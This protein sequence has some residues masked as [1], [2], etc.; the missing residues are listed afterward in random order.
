MSFSFG[1][2]PEKKVR[3]HVNGDDDEE[4]VGN[5]ALP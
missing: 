4:T 1:G 2:S 5:R 3:V